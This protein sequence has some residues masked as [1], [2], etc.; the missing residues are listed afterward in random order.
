MKLRN[1]FSSAILLTW[2]STSLAQGD[3]ETFQASISSDLLTHLLQMDVNEERFI[4]KIVRGFLFSGTQTTKGPTSVTFVENDHSAQI[5]LDLAL[6]SI[7]RQHG[8]SHLDRGIDVEID[9]TSHIQTLAHKLFFLNPQELT[10]NSAQCV[11]ATTLTL[12]SVSANASG[13]TR[14]GRAIKSKIAIKRVTRR[15]QENRR[16]Q[17]A[18]ISRETESQTC[19]IVDEK[20]AEFLVAANEDYRK[21]FFEPLFEANSMQDTLRFRTSIDHLYASVISDPGDLATLPP[22]TPID[23]L[24]SI[25]LHQSLINKLLT[26]ELSGITLD[27]IELKDLFRSSGLYIHDSHE[28]LTADNLV[29]RFCDQ[30]PIH[31]GFDKNKIQVEF[32]AR[33]LKLQGTN[34]GSATLSAHYDLI[35]LPNGTLELK[36][37]E[38]F[39]VEFSS[40]TNV[41][42]RDRQT[43]T[44][45]Y[46]RIFPKKM[47]TGPIAIATKKHPGAELKLINAM[48]S[49]GWLSFNWLIN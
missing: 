38:Q 21:I 37:L 1:I 9:T 24:L 25:R 8:R 29:L 48:A 42:D 17:E 36:Q 19:Q 4:S 47:T 46:Q 5:K 41:S 28:V 26:N 13:L 23:S 20:A 27:E 14:L 39:R 2:T 49:T 40:E 30:T 18:D 12:N 31:F 16:E 3:S 33:S 44:Q 6:H 11:S 7:S 34:L 43:V 22:P 35:P 45:R 10:A 32:C 15:F